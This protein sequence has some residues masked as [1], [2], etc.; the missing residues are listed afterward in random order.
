MINRVVLTFSDPEE[1]LSLAIK[2]F[3]QKNISCFCPSS[4]MKK[5]EV[6]IRG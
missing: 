4:L 1:E 2:Y 3:F 5:I 6:V